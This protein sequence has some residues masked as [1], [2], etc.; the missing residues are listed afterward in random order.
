MRRFEAESKGAARLKNGELALNW[1]NARR[2]RPNKGAASDAWLN[3]SNLCI[4]RE[5][6]DGLTSAIGQQE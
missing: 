5:A 6:R 1:A 4:R 3:T 2:Q